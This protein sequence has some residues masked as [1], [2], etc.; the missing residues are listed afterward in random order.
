MAAATVIQLLDDARET[1]A[2]VRELLT[3]PV[4]TATDLTPRE[5]V[6]ALMLAR[7]VDLAK[8]LLVLVELEP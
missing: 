1:A 7:K 3:L 2:L 6:L 4:L 8:R 5:A